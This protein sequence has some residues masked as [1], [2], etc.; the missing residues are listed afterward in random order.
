M[1]AIDEN[2]AVDDDLAKVRYLFDEAEVD[3]PDNCIN[4][5]HRVGKLVEAD[6]GTPKQQ[7]IVK[8]TTWHHII[9]FIVVK[10]TINC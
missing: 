8:F 5:V 6:D 10:K 9:V 3:I 2:K 7:V 4:R 1:P